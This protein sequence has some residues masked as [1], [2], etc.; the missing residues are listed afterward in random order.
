[1]LRIALF[2]G[3]NLDVLIGRDAEL[4][5]VTS[6]RDL[7]DQLIET[8][9]ELGIAVVPFHTNDESEFI[10]QMHATPQT[11]DGLLINAG[12]WGHYSW[13]LGDALRAAAIPAVEV[14]LSDTSQREEWRRASVV[15]NDCIATIK[16]E[17]PEGYVRG[18]KLLVAHLELK[19]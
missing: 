19:R 16:G 9:R 13:A 17:G 4:G 11:S 6:L 18:L 7:E 10:R 12:A 14:H 5:S 2:H 1:M 8:G 3:V 15:A